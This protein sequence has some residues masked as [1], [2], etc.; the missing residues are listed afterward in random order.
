MSHTD[1]HPRKF[2][3]RCYMGKILFILALSFYGSV[4]ENIFEPGKEYVYSYNATSNSGVL[5]PITA[6]S[7][8]GIYGTLVVQV[9][10]EDVVVMQLRDLQMDMQNGPPD[11]QREFIDVGSQVNEMSKPFKVTYKMGLV[12][13]F[14]IEAEPVWTTNIKRSIVGILQLDLSSLKKQAA[15]HSKE[16]NHYGQCYIE[17]VVSPQATDEIFVMKSTDPRTCVGHPF[18]SWSNVP[19]MLCPNNDQNPVLKSS[20]RL[21]RVK[22]SDAKNTILYINATGGIYVQPFQSLGEAQFLF[23][24]QVFTLLSTDNLRDKISTSELF[25]TTIQHV[26]PE[27]DFTQGRGLHDKDDVFESIGVLLDRLS[28]RLENPGLDT[29]IHNLH[30][31][32]ISQLLFY[33]SMLDQADLQVAYNKISGTS[34]KEETIRNMFLEALPQV[35]S[36]EA[37]LFV[38]NLVLNRKVSDITAIYLLTH[39]PFHIRKPDIQLLVSLQTLLNP[40]EK[41]SPE[42]HN[43]GILTYGTLIYKTC[44]LYC[45]YEMLD[46]YVRLYLDKFTESKQ[47][48]KKMVWLE[49]LSNIQLGKVVEFLEPIASGSNSE[50]RHLRFLAAWASLPTAPLRPD[51]IYPV[52]WPILV[53]RTELLEMRI[54]AMT[55]LIVS[56]PSSSRLISLYWYMQG[57]PDQHLYNF[58]YTTLK[59]MEHTNFPCYTQIGGIAAQFTRVLRKPASNQYIMTG[60]YL[61]DYQDTFRNFGAMLHAIIIADPR[62]NVPTVSHITL[63]NHGIGTNLN[64]VSLYIKDD[65]IFTGVL[66]HLQNFTRV[67]EVLQTFK[68]PE[69]IEKPLHMEIIARVQ[70]KAVLCMY[71]NQTNIKKALKIM[72][73]MVENAYHVYENMEFHINQQRINVPLTMESVQVTDLGTNVKIAGTVTSLF[74]MRGNFTHTSVGRNNHV[75]LRTSIHGTESVASYNPFT[76]LWH[77]AEREQSIHGYFPVNV[78]VGITDKLFLSYITP[79]E[80]IRTGVT[81]HVRTVTS[82]ISTRKRTILKNICKSCQEIYT[83]RKLPEN[84]LK[85]TKLFD[86]EVPELGGQLC[87]KVFDCESQ[88]SHDELLG[89]VL[90]SHR[91][92]YQIWPVIRS[93]ML[94]THVVDYFTYVPPGGSCGLAAYIEPHNLHSQDSIGKP[95]EV[96]LEYSKNDQYHGFFLTRR[97]LGSLNVLQKWSVVIFYETTSWISDKL[98]IKAS[99]TVPGGKVMKICI[100]IDRDS[101]WE[102]DFL[103]TKPSDPS[104]IKLHIA[105]GPADSAAGRCTGSSVLLNLVGEISSEQLIESAQKKW[106]YQECKEQA[107]GKRFTPYTEACYLASR[108]LSTLRKYEIFVRYENLPEKLSKTAW[109]LRAIYDLMGGNSSVALNTDQFFVTAIFPKDSSSGELHLNKDKVDIKYNPYIVDY[110]LT[111]TRLH[112]YMDNPLIQTFF[113][114]CVL[115]PTSIRTSYNVSISLNKVQEVLMLGDCKDNPGFTISAINNADTVNIIFND[116]TDSLKIIPNE[117][118][119]AV[120]N[121][122]QY[123]PL[124][125]NFQFQS[126]NQKKLRLDNRSVD[127]IVPGF[128]IF[129]HWTQEQVLIIYPNFRKESA[130]G[131]CTATNSNIGD[132]YVKL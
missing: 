117:E 21:Y 5:L 17:Y 92:N 72:L 36:K 33:L 66:E 14:S 81:A 13:N 119:G 40:P 130:C 22:S 18:W 32:T 60:N 122:E 96:K 67:K 64:H 30:N 94:G 27:N 126:M 35:G 103:S 50:S 104:S 106:P 83:V 9:P 42:V 118:G 90:S 19:V 63:N 48:E 115:T 61:L 89:D 79:S 58:F 77:G 95:T 29:E 78:T 68:L 24:Q 1:C 39:L 56:S 102:W 88:I 3:L 123:L 12:E 55:L 75:I 82:V 93:G 31:T 62:T 28:Q 38:Q 10:E 116:E 110:F 69:R 91:S 57:E 109:R 59:S 131:L 25:T 8:W 125:Q 7:S 71:F 45:P 51:V 76:D 15:F 16:V 128:L 124:P 65:G 98:K 70:Q 46:D 100:N 121:Y 43:T 44:L 112:K 132:A 127:L 74:S 114:S 34:Y 11:G 6:A 23:T 80:Y 49:G 84:T 26:L 99:R 101:L 47:Y 87:V 73:S 37:A 41:V 20:E 113:S 53:N 105:W 120:Y 97:E 107:R 86:V 52:Y 2:L 129:L 4:A 54:V 108:E 85:D 111:R